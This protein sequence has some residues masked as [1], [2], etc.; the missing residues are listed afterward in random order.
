MNQQPTQED[1]AVMRGRHKEANRKQKGVLLTELCQVVGCHRK[2]AIRGLNGSKG[3]G[4]KRPGL[5]RQYTSKMVPLLVKAWE[6]RDRVFSQ[7]LGAF[8][9][10]WLVCLDR[11]K[12]MAEHLRPAVHNHSRL[13][14]LSDPYVYCEEAE[15]PHGYAELGLRERDLWVGNGRVMCQLPEIAEA[16]FVCHPCGLTEIHL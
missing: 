3:T 11:Y 2:S 13:E 14:G 10:E 15:A 5:P 16:R 7:R 8:L 12:E 6:A 9:P 4:A 1:V